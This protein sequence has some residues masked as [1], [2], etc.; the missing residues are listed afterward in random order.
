MR[1]VIGNLARTSIATTGIL[2]MRMLTQAATLILVT[3]LLS[4]SLYGDYMAAASLAVVAGLVPNL[5]SGY[6]LMARAAREGSQA[7]EIW[8][9]GWPLSIC[10]GT[11]LCVVFPFLAQMLTQGTLSIGQ[12]FLIG[13]AE[14]LVTPLTQ[15]LSFVLQ[16]RDRVPQ[17]QLLLWL[18]FFLRAIAAAVCLIFV[19]RSS[20]HFFI[21]LQVIGAMTG[22]IVA[23]AVTLH[24]VRLPW[25]PRLPT[26]DEWQSGAAYA[27]MHVVAANPSEL[28]KMTSPLLLGNHAA[29]I[30][31]ASSRVMNAVVTPVLGLL[32]ASQPRLFRH[33]SAPTAEGR[34]L[35]RTLGY[36]GFAWGAVSAIGMVIAAPLLPYI[37]GQSFA[38]AA[39]TLPWIALAAPFVCLRMTAGTILVALGKPLQRLRFELSGI[40]LL[41]CLLATGAHV[42]GLRGMALGLACAE[43]CMATYGWIL[44]RAVRT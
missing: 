10:I 42:L 31:S 6:V 30:Y 9:Y 25:M 22:L 37:L 33:G 15:L 8:R 32:L 44:V 11:I 1:P 5:G 23:L 41:G 14:L 29:G 24:V 2:G 27:A 17:G 36:L 39:L 19:E 26:R 40:L 21:V 43:A 38:D 4:P 18:P 13:L 28:D 35:I 3:R 34:R 7:V 12:L 20:I 16:A